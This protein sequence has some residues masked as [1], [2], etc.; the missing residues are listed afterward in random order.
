MSV[1]D[2]NIDA[3][4][5]H[6]LYIYICVFLC[7]ILQMNENEGFVEYWN[8]EH[9]GW[10]RHGRNK[11]IKIAAAAQMLLIMQKEEW[12]SCLGHSG[13]QRLVT[14]LLIHHIATAPIRTAHAHCTDLT[15][16]LNTQ[17]P[18]V[19]I[20]HQNELLPSSWKL[21]TG[22]WIFLPLE[23]KS[24]KQLWPYRRRL[25]NNWQRDFSACFPL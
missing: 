15:H 14:R 6:F 24:E 20:F 7:Y 22:L 12:A 2:C 10:L 3:A 21:A 13:Q 9:L 16:T 18:T 17:N 19:R 4:F 5:M 8:S 25:N 1:N 11:G 23:N